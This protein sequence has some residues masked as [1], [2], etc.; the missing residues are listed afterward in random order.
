MTTQKKLIFKYGGRLF[1]PYRLFTKAEN[2]FDF[3]SFH[4]ASDFEIGFMN[5]DYPKSKIPYD[6]SEFY[7]KSSVK[8][9][10]LFFCLDNGK[11]YCPGINE[12]FEWRGIVGTSDF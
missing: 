11:L 10:D 9:C 7:K 6:Y 2:T 1:S 8:N 4:I 5:K 3:I 12:L